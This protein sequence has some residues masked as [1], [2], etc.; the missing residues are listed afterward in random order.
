MKYL[1][2]FRYK[3]IVLIIF[4][5]LSG[6]VYAHGV[7]YKSQ[8][9]DN[10][11]IRITLNWSDPN[12]N[13]GIGISY[14][15]LTNGKCLT[16]GYEVKEEAKKEEAKKETYFDFNL[17]GS[18]PPIRINLIDVNNLDKELFSDI[19]EV[20]NLEYIKHLHDMGILNGREDG[21]F[22]PKGQISRAEFLVLFIKALNI[23]ASSINE[24]NNKEVNEQEI[25]EFIN[26]YVDIKSH[27]ARKSII[28]AIKSGI[29]TGYNDKTIRPNN[30]ITV[31]E[32]CSIISRA[33]K[34][35]TI[36]D[37][38]FDKLKRNMWYSN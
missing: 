27:W 22:D 15:Y 34:F 13:K 28:T 19:K 12:N 4:F 26:N 20:K 6:S 7:I 32:V 35:R 29:I 36:K 18:V 25:N 38:I 17:N 33:F 1:Y 16:I 31:G 8:M 3:I 10:N 9:I 11:N 24:V 14:Y 37:G 30:S 5:C 21:S 23:K 2:F